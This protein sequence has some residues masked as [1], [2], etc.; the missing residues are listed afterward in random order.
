MSFWAGVVQATKDIEVRDQQEALAE[1]RKSVRDE[2][3]AY[4]NEETEYRRR[5]DEIN[6]K[7]QA[8]LDEYTASAELRTQGTYDRTQAEQNAAVRTA[9]RLAA[10]SGVTPP[11]TGGSGEGPIPAP[12]TL[13]DSVLKLNGWL[14]TSL[15]D[16]TTS[17]EDVDYITSVSE[18]LTDP[19][20]AHEFW[21]LIKKIEGTTGTMPTASQIRETIRVTQV[22]GY[23]ENKKKAAEYLAT[24]N[25]LD[26]TTPEGYSKSLEL[27]TDLKAINLNSATID[28]N[29]TNFVDINKQRP[30]LFK[31]QKTAFEQGILSTMGET[32]LSEYY[33]A[34]DGA[35]R[36]VIMERRKRT[37][38]Q[39]VLS[40]LAELY[41]TEFRAYKDNPMFRGYVTQSPS[42]VPADGATIPGAAPVGSGPAQSAE[43]QR[44]KEALLENPD[45]PEVMA[46]A[47]EVF[48]KEGVARITYGSG[49]TP[50]EGFATGKAEGGSY[51]IETGAPVSVED[52]GV[53]PEASA[54]AI[55]EQYGEAFGQ[56]GAQ[57]V[58]DTV[59]TVW[60]KTGEYM[61]KGA[62]RGAGM[63]LGS[64][65]EVGSWMGVGLG[66]VNETIG[67]DGTDWFE[68]AGELDEVAGNLWNN[69][70]SAAEASQ[71]IADIYSESLTRDTGDEERM[72][73]AYGS[74]LKKPPTRE[75]INTGSTPEGAAVKEAINSLVSGIQQIIPVTDSRQRIG[76]VGFQDTGVRPSES[77]VQGSPENASDTNLERMEQSRLGRVGAE[78]DRL[79]TESK[80]MPDGYTPTQM[81]ATELNLPKILEALSPETRKIV[82]AELQV[83]AGDTN[84]GRMEQSRL[85]RVGM[86]SDQLST[87]SKSMP[88]GYRPTQMGA[89]ELNSPKV[90][91]ALDAVVAPYV[92]AKGKPL[93][94]EEELAV[95]IE[96]IVKGLSGNGMDQ[97]ELDALIIEMQEKFGDEKVQE[98][99]VLAMNQ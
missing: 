3:R 52:F 68:S 67:L 43:E 69:G 82:E 23:A 49:F 70:I 50:S 20:D 25:N 33:S 71:K 44:R 58:A 72:A 12:K 97:A 18:T 74:E 76:T 19:A 81:G 89:T 83:T 60:N 80:S 40:E 87:E 15:S 1:E 92:E 21:S 22:P 66:F 90:R 6:L 29:L 61:L 94:P 63:A 98:A 17:Q 2:D 45:D 13:E 30:E 95:G 27:L 16:D 75:E 78:S 47:L 9:A 28:A 41:P 34:P 91:S 46:Q 59:K 14:E 10:G 56:E 84:L 7:R 35:A 11:A 39:Q 24:I 38:G 51:G 65:L 96:A 4:R 99:L 79:S 86:E 53:F 55:R 32:E 73:A 48:G 57:K 5:M 62:D 37:H 42:L 85:D 36:D 8:K 31:N 64:A 54:V 26:M 93:A 88:D 77:G